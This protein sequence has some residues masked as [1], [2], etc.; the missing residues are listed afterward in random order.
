MTETTGSEPPRRLPWWHILGVA[1]ALF[2]VGASA[3]YVGTRKVDLAN[4]LEISLFTGGLVALIWAVGSFVPYFTRGRGRFDPTGSHANAWR[5]ISK[6][7][8]FLLLL[9]LVIALTIVDAIGPDA[10]VGPSRIIHLA[11]S[12]AL[13][14][15][16]LTLWSDKST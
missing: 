1:L 14:W 5:D 7:R 16:I 8:I 10:F 13:V 2:A 6:D 4:R 11:A 9:S 3:M 12:V 15:R